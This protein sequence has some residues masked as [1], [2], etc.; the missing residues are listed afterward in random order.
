MDNIQKMYLFSFLCS[1]AFFGAISVPFFLDWGKINYTQIF[2]LQM[3]FSAWIFLL[4]IPTGAVA[5]KFGCKTSLILSSIIL[6]FACFLYGLFPNFYWFLIAEFFFALG[7]ALASG[8]DKALLYDSMKDLKKTKESKHFFSRYALFDTLGIVISF[9]LGSLIVGS[10]IMPYPN[11][12]A[13]G[14]LLTAIPIFLSAFVA[15]TIKSPRKIKLKEN[16]IKIGIRGLSYL[17]K[18]KALRSFAIDMVLISTTTFFMFWFYQPLLLNTGFELSYLGF[19]GSSFNI[20]GALLLY[21][22]GFLERKIGTK[23]LLYLTALIP[24]MMFIGLFFFKNIWFV[25]PSIFII[26]GLKLLREPLFDHYMNKFI[27][28]RERATVLSSVSMLRRLVLALF[29]PIVGI[30]SDISIYYALAF[31]G[32]LTILFAVFS[33]VDE[34][35][36]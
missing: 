10:K 28:A 22:V 14:M 1:M 6:S 16:V 18:H 36:L 12:L 24:G 25:L 29:Y 23:R 17:R 27:K 34:E 20:F 3:W 11:I 33:K 4:E 15:L 35:Y 13:L 32:V 19:V 8:A 7:L 31:L 26:T 9:P 5:D 21:K 2:I 30:I